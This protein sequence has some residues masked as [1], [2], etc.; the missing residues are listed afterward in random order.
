VFNIF[1]ESSIKTTKKLKKE[2]SKEEDISADTFSM[3]FIYLCMY[4]FIGCSLSK[5]DNLSQKDVNALVEKALEKQKETSIAEISELVEKALEKQKKAPKGD[6]NELVENVFKEGSLSKMN[7]I[8]DKMAEMYKFNL[9]V[10][11]AFAKNEE[12]LKNMNKNNYLS[13]MTSEEAFNWFFSDEKDMSEITYFHF[14]KQSIQNFFSPY[15]LSLFFKIDDL[16]EANKS[17]YAKIFAY[18][19]K[20]NTQK[21]FLDRVVYQL[22]LG[23]KELKEIL[24]EKNE[25]IF[26]KILS[27]K[28]NDS[29]V[30]F[31]LDNVIGSIVKDT[32]DDV[33]DMK[34][35]NITID[36]MEKF[37]NIILN[38]KHFKQSK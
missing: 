32:L 13:K 12:S 31:L 6:I 37:N 16:N 35:R 19:K 20:Y 7:K 4:L 3:K 33:S 10:I 24:N 38:T 15:E 17:I 11:Q 25:F 28:N 9:K 36:D 1:Y 8:F 14:E 22:S 34:M 30:P 29:D 27:I 2:F 23:D 26:T 18:I 21:Y 5:S